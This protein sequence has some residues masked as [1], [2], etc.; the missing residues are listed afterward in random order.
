MALV[1]IA[2]KGYVN[3]ELVVEGA[4]GHSSTPP[5]QT[6]IGILAEAISELEENPFPA[7]FAG[8]TRSMFDWLGPEMP[9]T[10]RL[11]LANLWLT[12]PV[13]TRMLLGS[14]QT[15]AMVRTTT[16]VTIVEGGVKANVLPIRARAVV[17]HRILPGDTKEGVLER[18]RAV[19]D[20][21]RVQVRITGSEAV[22]P[23]PV[24]D[25][26]GP[27]FRVLARTIRQVL[28]GEGVAVAPYLVMGGTDAKWYSGRSPSV[29]RFLAAPVG[30]DVLELAHGTNERMSVEGLAASIRFFQQLIR[31]TDTL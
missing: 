27:A 20:D 12:E 4:G 25:T 14:P 9:F 19:V 24:S 21:E 5:E 10:T 1:G 15:A 6:N 2:E 23:S 18:V 30:P 11:A 28:P 26:D 8:A 31:N 7:R 3:V 22:D 16:A 13:V 29:F 17:N